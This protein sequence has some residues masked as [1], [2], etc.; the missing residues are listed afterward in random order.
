MG[1]IESISIGFVTDFDGGVQQDARL[2]VMP[3]WKYL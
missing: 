3:R 2:G 1:G